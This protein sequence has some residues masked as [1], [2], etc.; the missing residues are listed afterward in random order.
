MTAL[1][2]LQQELLFSLGICP[3]LVYLGLAL[4]NNEQYQ[5]ILVTEETGSDLALDATLRFTQLE[6]YSQLWDDTLH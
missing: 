5:W 1:K 4:E 3:A 2:Y 6:V